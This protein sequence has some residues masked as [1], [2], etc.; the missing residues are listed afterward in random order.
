M[1]HQCK[2]VLLLL[3]VVRF[4]TLPVAAKAQSNAVRWSTFDMGF[5]TPASSN[6]IV[7]SAVG[8]TFVGTTRSLNNW[9]DSGFLA[10]T[11]FR[12]PLTA[13][14]A[15]ERNGIP[16]TYE[17][18]QN[19][20][21]PFN[22]STKIQFALPRESVVKLIVYNILGQEVTT[23]VDDVRPSGFHTADWSGMNAGGNRVSS[24]VYFYRLTAKDVAGQASY[25]SLKKMVLLR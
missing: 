5:A 9:I 3:L 13:V 25:S 2:C 15:N 24:G 22:P 18:G 10:D 21:N 11:L 4:F 16:S 12:G 19:Y 20:P 17:L 6:T 1:R 7:K 14:G 23:L 8:Q